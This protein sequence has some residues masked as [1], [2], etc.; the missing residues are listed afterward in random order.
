MFKLHKVKQE[1]NGK[2]KVNY[3]LINA[4][5]GTTDEFEVKPDRMPHPDF[6]SALKKLDVFLCD[7]NSL[8][9]HR[10]LLAAKVAPSKKAKITGAGEE[11]IEL[12]D[13]EILATVQAS[14]VV[15]FGSDDHRACVITGKHNTFNTAVAMNSPKISENGDT[16]GFE[17]DL[18]KAI[19][20]LIQESH[21]YVIKH[22]SS[23][24][25]MF[26]EQP[27]TSPAEA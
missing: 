10:T 18:F 21:D 14:G 20:E 25:N 7:S 12:L 22:K 3:S 26:S 23:Q 9:M 19:D 1:P 24:L 27:E 17:T 13:K 16:F 11:L 4:D 15:L 5:A 8:R 6:F 2:V